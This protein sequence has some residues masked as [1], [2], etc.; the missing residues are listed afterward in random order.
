MASHAQK[1]FIRLESNKRRRSSIHDITNVGNED[2]SH[3]QESIIDQSNGPIGATGESIKQSRQPPSTTSG[4]S[5]NSNKRRRSSIYD[6]TGVG[7]GDILVPQAPITGQPNGPTGE[8]SSP[9]PSS[10]F[11][12]YGPLTIGQ[13]IGESLVSATSTPVP[14]PPHMAYDVG[15]PYRWDHCT[16]CPNEHSSNDISNPHITED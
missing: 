13:L 3:P 2:I 14:A 4:G 6:I 8:H 15:A 5:M 10:T 11:G 1:Y 9:P 7:N 12:V 16:W